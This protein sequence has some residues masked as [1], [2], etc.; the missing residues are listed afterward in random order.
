MPPTDGH[1]RLSNHHVMRIDLEDIVDL[2]Q[3]RHCCLTLFPFGAKFKKRV[4]SDI[5]DGAGKS[6]VCG[7]VY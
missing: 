1:Y 5:M 6:G 2:L 4:M 3:S 7:L